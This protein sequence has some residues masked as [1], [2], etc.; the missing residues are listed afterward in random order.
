MPDV[1]VDVRDAAHLAGVSARTVTRWLTE[2]RL[3]RYRSG[4]LTR[5][6]RSE[7][8]SFIEP[9]LAPARRRKDRHA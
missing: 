6:N 2:N 1:F 8:L 3:Q 4:S 9:R 5:I 7:L